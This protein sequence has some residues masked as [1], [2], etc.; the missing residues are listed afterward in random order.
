MNKTLNIMKCISAFFVICIH[1][2]LHNYGGKIGTILI[3]L[4]RC[5]VPIF[6]LISGYYSY[7]NNKNNSDIMKK[8]KSRMIKLIK[9]IIISGI[10][11][12]L[13]DILILDKYESISQYFEWKWNEKNFFKYIF[14]NVSPFAGHLWFLSALLYCYILIFILN[15]INVKVSILYK[16]IPILLMMN[17]IFGE[18][19]SKVGLNGIETIYYRNFLFYGLP[20]FLIGYLINDKSKKI[21]EISNKTLIVVNV[22]SIVLIIIELLGTKNADLYIGSIIQAT[23]LFILCVRNPNIIDIKILDNIGGKLYTYIYIYHLMVFEMVKKYQI[24]LGLRYEDVCY[25]DTII[26]FIITILISIMIY[27]VS[28]YYKKIKNALIVKLS[29]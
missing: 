25:K 2:E 22:L 4:M 9:L 1:C 29:N 3:S 18:I 20:F 11:Y 14:L 6:F 17:I 12:L 10:T 13:F 5:S 16:Y 23:S 7:F 19:S 21:N 27:Y 15:K 24:K 26:V 28:I 8:Y